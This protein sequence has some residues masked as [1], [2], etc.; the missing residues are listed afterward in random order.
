[1]AVGFIAWGRFLDAAGNKITVPAPTT[2]PHSPWLWDFIRSEAA[3]LGSSF[4]IVQL[5]PWS[6]AQGGAGAGCDGYGVFQR[7]NLN[8]T[9]YGSLESLMA[10]VAALNAHGCQTYG[11]LVL[12]QMI[13]ENGGPGVFRYVGADGKTMNGRGQTT[14]GWFRGGM[15]E[16]DPI[17]PFCPED[18]VPVPADDFPFGREVSYQH[19]HPAQVTE[20]DAKDYLTWSQARTGAVGFR[21]DDTKGTWAPA[22][23]AIMDALPQAPFYSE[24]FDGDPANLNWWTTSAPLSGRSAV[25]DFT[26]HFAIQAACNGFDATLFDQGS[27]G[28]WQWNSGLSVGFV[29][30]PDTDTTPGEQVVFNKGIAYA[31]LLTLPL[32]LAL[33]YGKDYYPSSVWPG[34]YGLRPLID[35]LCWISRMFAVGGYQVRWVDRDVHVASRDGNGGPIGWSGGLLTA[36]NFNTLSPRTITCSTPFGPN[37]WLHDYTG[38]HPDIWTDGNGNAT[39]TIPSNAWSG[40]QSYLCFAPSG[41][42]RPY[43]AI[44]RTTTQTV[45][46]AADLDVMPARNQPAHLPQRIYCMKNTSASLQLSASVP[47]NGAIAATV[48]DTSGKVIAEHRIGTEARHTSGAVV[49]TGWHTVSVQGFGLPAAGSPF[50]LTI[51]YTGSAG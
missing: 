6:L 7:R 17:P 24:Y 44:A 51:T 21:F 12:H 19:C 48:S 50:H 4:D 13:G 2:E 33:V 23:R 22:V 28:Y 26:L 29:D 9:R 18:D 43:P 20:N 45:F 37:R 35:N 3:A 31:Y 42:S 40:G 11:D 10:A 25:E 39:F 36:I 41:V 5:P 14:P 32:R 30:N 38:H 16:D 27:A 15:K 8:G 47:L 49:N 34:A 1:M 46:A